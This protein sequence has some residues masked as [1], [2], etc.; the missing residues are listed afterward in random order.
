MSPVDQLLILFV[1][2]LIVTIFVGPVV[3][4]FLSKWYVGEREHNGLLL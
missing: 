2:V 4:A 1:L 3:Y